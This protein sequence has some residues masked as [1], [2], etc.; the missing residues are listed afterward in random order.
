MKK[1][2]LKN[3]V[4]PA[5][6]VVSV[7]VIIVS[8]M[9]IG[10]FFSKV[11]EPEDEIRFVSEEKIV[12]DNDEPV[13]SVANPTN[14]TVNHP[15][16]LESVEIAKNFYDK[17]SNEESQIKSL[18]YYKNTY[19]ENTGVIYTNNGKFD[20]V[21]VLD[22]TVTSITKDEILGNV[23]EI[24]HTN[25]LITVYSCLDEVFVKVGDKV[26]QNDVIGNSG[27]VSIDKGYD[28]ALLFEVNYK[29]IIINPIEFYNMKVADLM[30]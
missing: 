8:L 4:I 22:G 13:L 26:K 30:E 17:N 23:I 11:T 14:E 12:N 10:K 7:S 25:E 20:V 9:F 15:Y 16:L 1:Y 24:M 2:K 19:M 28:N 27:S 21:S 3:W 18:I 5:I 6:Y 29:G